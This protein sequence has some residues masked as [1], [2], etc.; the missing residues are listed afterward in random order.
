MKKIEEKCNK[1]IN[2]KMVLFLLIL[3]GIFLL[4]PILTA[5]FYAH[6]SADDFNYGTQTINV[7]QKSGFF[8]LIAGVLNTVKR[9]YM[10]WQGTFS[11]VIVMSLNPAVFGD[12]CYFI[13][14]FFILIVL[15][16]SLSYLGKIV[17]EKGL[18]C[19]KLTKWIITISFFLLMVETLPDK[20]QGLFWWNGA[21][22]YL[23]FFSLELF[24]IS[25]LVKRY[26]LEEKTL[27][28]AFLVCFLAAFLGGGNY[29]VALQ[30]MIL[31]FFLNAYLI[32]KKK[33]K[34]AILPFVLSILSFGVNAMAPGNAVRGGALEGLSPVLAILTSFSKAIE[35]MVQ[36]TSPLNLLVVFFIIILLIPSYK[37]IKCK[38]QY[39]LVIAFFAYCIFSAEFTPSLY[40]QATIGDGRLINIIYISYHLFLISVL[41]YIIGNIREKCY[42]EKVFQK[43]SLENM[44]KVVKSNACAFFVVFALIISSILIVNKGDMTSYQTYAIL[45]RGEA[46]VYHKEYQERMKILHDDKI[47]EVEFEPYTYYPTPIFFVDF[48]E[49]KDS[50]LNESAIKIYHKDYIK[51]KETKED[52]DHE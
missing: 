27:W 44:I 2:K 33:D 45:R 22:Y 49:D 30:Q 26:F 19:D 51:I 14:T 10:T 43:S 39:P 15:F 32:F 40:A 8:G 3:V 46:Q 38:F 16:L 52:S 37:H 48:S 28:N 7:L 50:W 20:T 41:Y 34:S 42:K 11:A 4:I 23:F 1:F 47:K 17:I 6:P 31:F 5:S 29:V 18:K 12:N 9:F 25:L 13:T 21:V 35:Q 24:L 36:W